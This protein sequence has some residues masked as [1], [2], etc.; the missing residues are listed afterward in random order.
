MGSHRPQA[1]TIGLTLIGTAFVLVLVLHA[2]MRT[3]SPVRDMISD[4]SRQPHGWLFGLAVLL[5]AAGSA[6]LIPWRRSARAGVFFA[7]WCAGLV[8]LAVCRRD[9]PGGLPTVIGQIH[10]VA[11]LVALVSLP[12]GVLAVVPRRHT[13]RYVAVACLV[14]L[15]PLSASFILGPPWRDVLGLLERLLSVAELAVV[16]ALG[17]PQGARREVPVRQS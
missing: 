3:V 11:A 1:R 17:S 2:T 10:L 8:V 6:L 13:L 14:M 12:L 5:V 9:V 15:V 7:A 4:Y 16:A